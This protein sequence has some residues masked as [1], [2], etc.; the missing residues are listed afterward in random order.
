MSIIFADAFGSYADNA[1]GFKNFRDQLSDVWDY[2]TSTTGYIS[3]DQNPHGYA[4]KFF[5]PTQSRKDYSMTKSIT[6]STEVV[7]AFDVILGGSNSSNAMIHLCPAGSMG[8]AVA[9]V[10]AGRFEGI[11]LMHDP[12]SGLKIEYGIVSSATDQGDRYIVSESGQLLQNN[13]LYH[14]EMRVKIAGA[15]SE[16]EV[17]LNESPLMSETFD[18]DRIDNGWQMTSVAEVTICEIS[19]ED[20]FSNLLIYAPDA[21][22]VFPIGLYEFEY[23]QPDA[24][25]GLRV[26]ELTTGPD[27]ST[28]VDVTSP[29]F[30]EYDVDD[31]SID[32]TDIIHAQL[33]V[34][35]GAV[36]GQEPAVAE[37]RVND[38]VT[39]SDV[40]QYTIAPDLGY[41]LHFEHI[42]IDTKAKADA[43]KIGFRRL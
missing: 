9:T 1:T 31:A 26:D 8:R 43:A 32:A 36:Q 12:S 38:G 29:T 3:I 27:H 33:E 34:A 42:N 2:V 22:H 20:Y 37:V 10:Y 41:T 17:Y 13:T 4:G 11:R 39:V 19:N 28:G 35:V 25:T 5:H 7:V 30:T 16:V 18:S 24:L 14:V 23:L 15:A 40:F 21:Q 6:P